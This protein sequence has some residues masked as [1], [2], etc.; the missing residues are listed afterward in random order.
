MKAFERKNITDVKKE[1][2]EEFREASIEEWNRLE[3]KCKC[4]RLKE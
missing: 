1:G 4:E 2:G 3:L